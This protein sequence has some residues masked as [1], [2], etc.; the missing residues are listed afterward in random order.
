MIN[1]LPPK[2]EAILLR[3]KKFKLVLILEIIFFVF[4]IFLILVLLSIKIHITDKVEHQKALLREE[5]EPQII[6]EFRQKINLV[7]KN[8]SKL[9]EFYQQKTDLT[10]VLEKIS[11]KLFPGMYLTSISYNQATSLISLFGFSPTR[12]LLLGEFKEDL[13]SEFKEVYFPTENLL[14]KYDID[15]IVN[16]KIYD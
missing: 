9:N 13:E 6:Q 5:S 15:F 7:N 2:E 12:D 3:E 10:E 8:I 14:K 1:L 16:F 4:L 11:T